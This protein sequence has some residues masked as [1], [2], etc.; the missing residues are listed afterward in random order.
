[1]NPAQASK[2]HFPP[3]K[4]VPDQLLFSAPQYNLWIHCL[5]E[6]TQ[7]KVLEYASQ[8]V[9]SGFPPG[10]IM[11]DTNWCVVASPSVE[12]LQC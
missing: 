7:D 11:I 8:A 6:P 1:M 2:L 3:T 5:Y 12:L 10:V 9:A 4:R